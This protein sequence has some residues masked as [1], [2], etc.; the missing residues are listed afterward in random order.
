MSRFDPTKIKT[1]PLSKRAH[2][3]KIAEI[4]PLTHKPKF[5]D[6]ESKGNLEALARRMEEARRN[7]APIIM[8]MGS[9]V[10]T[11]GLSRFLI[12]LIKD[13]YITHLGMGGAGMIHD[14]ELARVGGT[15]EDV[16]KY[17]SKGEYG[18]WN[19]VGEINTIVT[20]AASD[21]GDNDYG[22]GEAIGKHM[23]AATTRNKEFP[24]KKFSVVGTTVKQKVPLTVHVGMGFDTNHQHQNFQPAAYGTLSYLDFLTLC[25][26]VSRLEGGVLLNIGTAVMGP[27]VF[28]TA[29]TMARNVAAQEGKEIKRFTTAVFDIKILRGNVVQE[30][31]KDDPQYHFRP[32]KT[33]LCRTVEAG[34][35][36]Y[37]RGDHQD[38]IPSLREAL[39][40]LNS[41]KKRR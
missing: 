4:L 14:F 18:L 41:R 38:T 29:L 10:I 27:E 23:F 37:V 22:L 2:Q 7:K 40:R 21:F 5:L 13:K 6:Y 1:Q 30:P 26:T 11:R 24:F 20:K 17:V 25:D 3:A 19:E 32:W 12:E 34:E 16:R 35:S 31:N 39:V 15:S 9:H 33:I 8:L 36:Y 28:L